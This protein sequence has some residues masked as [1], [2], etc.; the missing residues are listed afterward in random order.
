MPV[1][2]AT[3]HQLGPSRWYPLPFRLK[4]RLPCD[5]CAKNCLVNGSLLSR[6]K[7]V[8]WYHAPVVI[9]LLLDSSRAT[10]LLGT[11]TWLN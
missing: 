5:L 9:G 4:L 2:E 7:D 1:S 6:H 10:N 3:G 11:V 8:T